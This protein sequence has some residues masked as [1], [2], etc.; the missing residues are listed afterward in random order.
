MLNDKLIAEL[1]NNSQLV[2]SLGTV[3]ELSGNDNNLAEEV[4]NKLKESAIAIF[5]FV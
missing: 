3:L 5:G 2:D 4:G 1:D